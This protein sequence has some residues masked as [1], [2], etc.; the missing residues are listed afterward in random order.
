MIH[1]DFPE[2]AE[3][4]AGHCPALLKRQAAPAELLPEFERVGERLSAMLRPA[5][6]AVCSDAGV[7]VRS[8]GVQALSGAGLSERC[9][10]PGANSLHPFGTGERH[11]FLSLEGRA[12]LAQLDRAFGGSGEVGKNLP[13]ELPLSADL[14]AQRLEKQVVAALETE[15]AG[16]EFRKGP[17]EPNIA[18]LAPFAGTAELTLLELEVVGSAAAPWRIVIAVEAEA[19]HSLLPRRATPR[20]VRADRKAGVGD[21][22]FADLPLAASARL[23]DMTVPLHRL[24]S[25]APGAVLPIIVARSVPLQIGETVVA[26]GTVG[27]VDDQVALQI[28]QTFS[29]K[30]S[31]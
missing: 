27:D 10:A 13:A 18:R 6:E 15:L 19:L 25:L 12:M 31:K 2:T 24:A 1:Q 14:L 23:V 16:I 20:A 26:R 21:A 28:T 30:E 22:P 7:Q 8:L 29:G 9:P 17:R 3:R 5:L 11:L 4:A